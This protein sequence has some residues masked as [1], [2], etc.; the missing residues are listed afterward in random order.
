[1]YLF[2]LTS[3]TFFDTILVLPASNNLPEETITEIIH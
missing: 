3:T 2:T 1:M